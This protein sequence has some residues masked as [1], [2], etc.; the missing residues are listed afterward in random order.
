[1][2]GNGVGDLNSR[3]G[4]RKVNSLSTLQNGACNRLNDEHN[5]SSVLILGPK[6]VCH[7]DFTQQGTY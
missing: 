4:L 6:T 2:K 3:L 5:R 7:R 1:M